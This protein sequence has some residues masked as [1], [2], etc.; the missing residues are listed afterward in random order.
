MA[1]T[2]KGTPPCHRTFTKSR[3][4]FRACFAGRGASPP[5]KWRA[6]V[7][8]FDLFQSLLEAA[9]C[10]EAVAEAARRN[11]PGISFL[12]LLREG[13]AAPAWR[14]AWHC[15]YGNAR[16]IRGSRFKLIV[17]YAPHAGVFPDELYDLE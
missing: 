10:R 13:R 11:S 15:A 16:M 7:N 4:A 14:A 8:H 9:D 2:L 3:S 12:P 17:R 1:F 6:P 5:G